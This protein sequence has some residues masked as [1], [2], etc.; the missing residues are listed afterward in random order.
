MLCAVDR[1]SPEPPLRALLSVA[2]ALVL[3]HSQNSDISAAERVALAPLRCN[4]IRFSQ[5]SF[6]FERG[7]HLANIVPPVDR[8]GDPV[9]DAVNEGAGRR[10]RGCQPFVRCA[11]VF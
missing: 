6:R 10:G 11:G 9:I 4:A 5:R 8:S 7:R 1:L 2:R 3:F